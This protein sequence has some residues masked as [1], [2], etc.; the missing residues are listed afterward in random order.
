M[1]EE[2]KLRYQLPKRKVIALP[3]YRANPI[4]DIDSLFPQDAV[5]LALYPQTTCFY[6]GVVEQV[7]EMKV[8]Q[9]YNSLTGACNSYRRLFG[10]IRGWI[11]PKRIFTTTTRTAA[12]CRRIPRRKEVNNTAADMM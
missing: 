2:Q 8:G 11:I 10:R 1:D 3:Q 5:V 6:K 4:T 12:I 9:I 7:I